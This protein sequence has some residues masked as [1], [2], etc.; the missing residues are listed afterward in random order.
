[1]NNTQPL[2]LSAAIR[3]GSLLHPVA[4]PEAVEQQV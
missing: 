3:L 2:S 1:M 4:E